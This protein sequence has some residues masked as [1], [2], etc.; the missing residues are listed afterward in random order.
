MKIGILTFHRALNY[1]AVLQAYA[2]CHFL[3]DNDFDAEIIDYRNKALETIYH[4]SKINLNNMQQYH[5]YSFKNKIQRFFEVIYFKK[6]CL[7][8][9]SFLEKNLSNTVTASSWDKVINQYDWIVT[10][11]DQV[12]NFILTDNDVIYYLQGVPFE[13]RASFAAS[14]GAFN[15]VKNQ[16]CIDELNLFS[17]LSVRE[18]ETAQLF[19]DITKKKCFCHM[20]PV[21]LLDKKEWITVEKAPH[22]HKPYI[23]IFS[24][25]KSSKLVEKA[26]AY[27]KK[28]NSEVYFLSTALKRKMKKGIRQIWNAS[29]YEFLGWI[30]HADYIFT[31]SFHGTAFSILFEKR[32]FVD[33]DPQL[34]SSNRIFNVLNY[35][36]CANNMNDKEIGKIA[37]VKIENELSNNLENARKYFRK[38]KD[39]I[40]NEK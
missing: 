21:F 19:E 36:G 26:L 32:F 2:L 23:L 27:A 4:S 22:I 18:E 33:A 29:P 17:F 1:G 7:K 13:K 16:K 35:F 15:V 8:F 11:S 38:F 37:E 6:L 3:N 12:F 31:D 20:D 40:R 14:A 25:N 5:G 24:M 28:N 9:D 10:G 39:E 30:H 34:G